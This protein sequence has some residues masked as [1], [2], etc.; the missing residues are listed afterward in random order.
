MWYQN[1]FRTFMLL[2]SK[3]PS[4]CDI[5][6]SKDKA[7]RKEYFQHIIS[8]SFGFI[9]P[10][11]QLSVM[12]PCLPK[13]QYRIFFSDI[14]LSNISNIIDLWCI[15][16]KEKNYKLMPHFHLTYVTGVVDWIMPQV[17]NARK[18]N[19]LWKD[20]NVTAAESDSQC[21]K[22]IISFFLTNKLAWQSKWTTKLKKI[23]C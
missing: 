18:C 12:Q 20:W 13:I 10:G 1:V 14:S 23:A 17:S 7:K 15:K 16:K 2:D 22:T 21:V 3:C 6:L 11:F 19:S 8:D 5:Y 9:K 4:G